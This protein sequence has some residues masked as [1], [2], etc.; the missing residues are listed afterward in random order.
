M[1]GG[2]PTDYRDEFC[3]KAI[4]FGKLGYSKTQIADKF[5]VTKKTILLWEEKY[6]EFLHAM[7][8]A[9]I[10]SQAWWENKGQTHLVEEYQGEKINAGLYSRSMAAR[11]PDDWRESKETRL[12]G[13]DGSGLTINVTRFG[14]EGKA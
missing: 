11:F 6:P 2:R 14:E 9:M 12:S 8:V 5:D 13:A 3:Q 1:A 10:K 4:E 7:E